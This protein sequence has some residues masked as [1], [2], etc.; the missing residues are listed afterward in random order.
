M[1]DWRTLFNIFVLTTVY[2]IS[3][4]TVREISLLVAV[5]RV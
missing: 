5:S 2:E 4:R 1:I 3:G